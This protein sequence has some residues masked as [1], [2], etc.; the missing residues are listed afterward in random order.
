[1]FVFPSAHDRDRAPDFRRHLFAEEIA[2]HVVDVVSRDFRHTER[3]SPVNH[4]M[5]RADSPT[6]G[7]RPANRTSA[8]PR[9][10]PRCWDSLPVPISTSITKQSNH[11]TNKSH[12]QKLAPIYY[13]LQHTQ[14]HHSLVLTGM[15]VNRAGRLC[16]RWD[17]RK[18]VLIGCRRAARHQNCLPA[19]LTCAAVDTVRWKNRKFFRPPVS[20]LPVDWVSGGV[21][22]M[23]SRLKLCPRMP[24][25]AARFLS[26]GN[27]A[28]SALKGATIAAL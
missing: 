27:L 8:S 17:L 9:N 26:T 19:K 11:T 10:H 24:S 2:H 5:M 28:L 6:C 13:V 21:E 23:K 20:Q 3:E 14:L 18:V 25:G 4:W 7:D 1:M 22:R 16:W 12:V 15:K